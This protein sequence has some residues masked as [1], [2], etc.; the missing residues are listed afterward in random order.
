MKLLSI[1]SPWWWW[2][3][4]GDKD[5][6]NRDWRGPPR[7]RGPILIH[8]SAWWSLNQVVDDWDWC[9][10]AYRQER[11]PGARPAHPGPKSWRELKDMGG[12]I[13]GSCV[14]QDVVTE[15]RSPWFVGK[16]GFVLTNPKPLVAP[17]PFKA[18]L[19]LVDVPADVLD[20]VKVAA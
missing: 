19:G 6:E 8:A 10:A 15:S 20:L 17:V 13:V 9:R 4:Y 3:L 7:Y 11:Q 18:A 14:L 2:I 16:L 12:H 1:R 5:I